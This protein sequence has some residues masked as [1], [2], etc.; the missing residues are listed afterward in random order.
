MFVPFL[1]N[2]QTITSPKVI[3]SDID[4]YYLYGDTLEKDAVISQYYFVKDYCQ[5]INLE[6]EL[7]TIAAGYLK[8]STI[9]YGSL[10]Y[11]DWTT[12]T[13]NINSTTLAATFAADSVIAGTVTNTGTSTISTAGATAATSATLFRD[14]YFKYIKVTSTA[15]DSTQYGQYKHRILFNTNK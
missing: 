5:D 2:A 10:N 3:T 9:V 14:V 7:D 8:V 1:M 6:I 13:G 15:I 11:R 12:L 4:H